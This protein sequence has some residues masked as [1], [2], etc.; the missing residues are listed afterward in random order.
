MEVRGTRAK[1]RPR[2]RSM[3]NIRHGMNKTKVWR[4]ETPKTG[5]DGTESRPGIIAGHG[6]R[7]RRHKKM[8]PQYKPQFHDTALLQNL[9]IVN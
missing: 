1:G 2:M 9:I 6:G 4:R 8:S 5:E 3:D 7:G